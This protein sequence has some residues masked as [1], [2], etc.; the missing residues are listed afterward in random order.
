MNIKS[1]KDME[2]ERW[3][4]GQREERRKEK[5]TRLGVPIPGVVDTLIHSPLVPLVMFL[6]ITY[7]P[8][9]RRRPTGK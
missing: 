7:S 4:D 3:R 9:L 1:K 6:T 2:M 8:A 5:L